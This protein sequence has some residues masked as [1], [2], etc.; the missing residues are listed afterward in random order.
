[1]AGLFPAVSVRG[2]LPETVTPDLTRRAKARP[3]RAAPLDSLSNCCY[4][5]EV[6]LLR[7]LHQSRIA[8]ASDPA[9]IRTVSGASIGLAELR[10]V[11]SV[12]EFAT[13]FLPRP[14]AAE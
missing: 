4:A 9:K 3:S 6:E 7:E 5:L 1:M 8:S 2:K 11:A 12:V 14:L 13:K 10:V